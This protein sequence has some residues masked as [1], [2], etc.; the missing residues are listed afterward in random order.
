MQ[1]NSPFHKLL[2]AGGSKNYKKIAFVVIDKCH[3]VED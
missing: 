3:L 2:K 1:A